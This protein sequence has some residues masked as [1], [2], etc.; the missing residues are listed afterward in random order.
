MRSGVLILA[1]AGFLLTGFSAHAETAE[2]ECQ[3]MSDEAVEAYKKGSYQRAVELLNRA[4]AIRPYTPLLYNLAKAYDKLNDAEHAY[5]AY[6][7]YV[8]SGES[9]PKLE[10]KARKR[11]EFFE[12]QLKPKKP[13]EPEKVVETKVEEPKPTGPT[14]EELLTAENDRRRRFRMISLY[15]GI[16]VAAVGVA[17][18]AAGG[19]TFFAANDKASGLVKEFDETKKRQL[20]DE[21]Q[22]LGA[23]STALYGVGI[24]VALIGA[25]GIVL[26]FVLPQIQQ[27]DT[28]PD[29]EAK[30]VSF[31]PWVS[32]Q[33]A[34]A[35][36]SWRF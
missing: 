27:T 25:A 1:L 14:P 4:Y 33:G 32:P 6:K 24:P 23:S 20:R 3:R 29:G 36:V 30:K 34:G 7:K 15:G 28:L 8:D 5:E 12:P 10:E 35:N 22:S 26:S 19:G 17:L 21:A 18:I 9:E 2:Q 13:V 16:G 31:A 11:M